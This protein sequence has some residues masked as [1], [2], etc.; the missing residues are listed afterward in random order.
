MDE[1]ANLLIGLALILLAARVSAQIAVALKLPSVFGV[2]LA[3]VI[4]GPSVTGLVPESAALQGMSTV[5]VVLLLFVA[6]I[7]TDLVQM[8]RVGAA[9][10]L[11]AIGGVA[12]PMAGAYVVARYFGF[13][14][15]E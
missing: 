15:A 7:E 13:G 14:N 5:G 9:A 11:A 4:L 2:L 6:G 10:T 8:R 1:T 3:G 12:A